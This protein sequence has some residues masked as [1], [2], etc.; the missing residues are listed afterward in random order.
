M[1]RDI[2]KFLELPS[3]DDVKGCHQA[4]IEVTSNNAI[5][6]GVCVICTR[7]KWAFEGGYMTIL[8]IPNIQVRLAPVEEKSFSN[9]WEGIVVV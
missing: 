2:D 8:D 5:A 9:C 7:E 6:S 4:F 3:E 1:D